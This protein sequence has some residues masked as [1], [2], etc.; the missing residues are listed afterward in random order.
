MGVQQ[1]GMDEEDAQDGRFPGG[2][3]GPPVKRGLRA[4]RGLTLKPV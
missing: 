2:F 4:R 3:G 1:L